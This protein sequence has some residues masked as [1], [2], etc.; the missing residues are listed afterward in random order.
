MAS[1]GLQGSSDRNLPGSLKRLFLSSH[2]TRMHALISLG[3]WYLL[4]HP[5]HIRVHEDPL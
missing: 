5:N 3:L 1:S 4:D 2:A